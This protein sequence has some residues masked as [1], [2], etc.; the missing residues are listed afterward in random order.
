MLVLWPRNKVATF[1][2][3]LLALWVVIRRI[4]QVLSFFAFWSW[5]DRFSVF[6]VTFPFHNPLLRHYSSEHTSRAHLGHNHAVGP[7]LWLQLCKNPLVH[8]TVLRYP[9]WYGRC[10]LPYPVF[11]E[12]SH[13]PVF[14]SSCL[15]LS[16]RWW[17]DVCEIWTEQEG[18]YTL[19]QYLN[20][21]SS[22][23]GWKRWFAFAFDSKPRR[24]ALCCKW[25]GAAKG[26]LIKGLLR[27]ITRRFARFDSC[28][29]EKSVFVVLLGG[30]FD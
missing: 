17:R 20:C 8:L 24:M 10:S 28:R 2:G 11:R 13:P 6:S 9:G 12:S 25:R 18:E 22:L 1:A 29:W 7:L 4:Q 16:A 21:I 19:A 23:I 3:W 26:V 5:N 27:S 14:T 30:L 15:V